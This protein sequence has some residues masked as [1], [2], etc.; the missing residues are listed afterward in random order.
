MGDP[1][2]TSSWEGEDPAIHQEED[3][4]EGQ[5]EDRLEDQEED[6]LE[7]QEEDHPEDQDRGHQE[8]PEQA[9]LNTDKHRD[10]PT[11]SSEE[12]LKYSKEIAPKLRNLSRNGTCSSELTTQTQPF[13]TLIK[14]V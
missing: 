3:Q 1:P 7:D 2:L 13:K 5:E 10:L 11:S 6:R 12:N 8:D 4:L 14:G 9:E